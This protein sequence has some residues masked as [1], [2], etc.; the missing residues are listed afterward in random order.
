MEL[1]KENSMSKAALILSII[2]GCSTFLLPFYL[3]CFF[4][5]ISMVLA[6]L[7]K[8]NQAKLSSN[9][10]A[11]LTISVISVVINVVILAGCFYLVFNVPEFQEAF[12]QAYQQLYG[13]SF[14]VR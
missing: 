3:P 6:L 10:K 5:G 8:G 2:G 14:F 11:A 12:D 1:Q 13:E 7:S 4:G 9:A